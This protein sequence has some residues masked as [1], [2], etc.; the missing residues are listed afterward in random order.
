MIYIYG[1]RGYIT[2]KPDEIRY[3]ISENTLSEDEREYIEFILKQYFE[4]STF[5]ISPNE[6]HFIK[7]ILEQISS[8]FMRYY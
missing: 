3:H 4:N 8:P 2:L 6:D 1:K 5:S 7:D